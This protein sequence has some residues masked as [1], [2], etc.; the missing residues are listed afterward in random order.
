MHGRKLTSSP[1]NRSWTAYT[2]TAACSMTRVS[3]RTRSCA[4]AKRYA[5]PDVSYHSQA[6]SDAL[7][8]CYIYAGQDLLVHIIYT[9]NSKEISKIYINGIL[10]GNR[11]NFGNL[12]NWDPNYS[13]KLADQ[14]TAVSPWKGFYNLISFYKRALSPSEIT[15]NFSQ[16]PINIYLIT[17]GNLT[18]QANQTRKVDLKWKDNSNN[19]DGLIIER[20][21]LGFGF[22]FVDSLAANDTSY[23]DVN[24]KD[25]TNYTYRIK[26]YNLFA[27]SNFSNEAS[28]TTLQFAIN[29]P[30]NLV[31]SLIPVEKLFSC[32][33]GKT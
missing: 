28:V 27:E 12:S 14:F 25:T 7:F 15:H 29:N 33:K 4:R 3:G 19:E 22:V 30:T 13:L 10:V 32:K 23:T 20:K 9:H 16:G 24:L 21:E 5:N 2:K 11:Y 17:P 8:T 26:A 31:A 1:C 6:V 18:A